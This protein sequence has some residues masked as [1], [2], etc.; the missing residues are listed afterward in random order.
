MY[1]DIRY[2][3]ING[4]SAEKLISDREWYENYFIPTVAKRGAAIIDARGL[5]SA[6]SAANAAIDHIRDWHNGSSKPWTTMGVPS[7]GEYNIPENIIFG[8]PCICENN[9]YKIVNDL[10]IDEFSQKMID[11]TLNELIEEQKAV[12][13]LLKG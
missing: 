1:P 9:D 12:E 7:N 5:S 10:D 8:F 3:K 11:K 13:S 2:T 6:A 4:E